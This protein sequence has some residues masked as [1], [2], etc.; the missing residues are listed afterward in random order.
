M[1]LNPFTAKPLCAQ[2]IVEGEFSFYEV[3]ADGSETLTPSYEEETYSGGGDHRLGA[4]EYTL[5][6]GREIMQGQPTI[7]RRVYRRDFLDEKAIYFPEHVRAFDDQFF[8][9]M[10]AQHCGDLAHVF[11]HTYHYRQHP[12]Q[13]I[14]QRDER[15]FYS[16]NMFRQIL[17]RSL[18]EAWPDFVPVVGSL[19]GSSSS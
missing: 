9:L 2:P 12:A 7:W 16:F 11:G 10:S 15:H 8:Q 1:T 6:P 5:V 18:R 14:K 13:D 3:A 19:R 17:L 4:I